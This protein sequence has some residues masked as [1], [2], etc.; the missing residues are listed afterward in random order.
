MAE[1]SWE[2]PREAV[3]VAAPKRLKFAV[4]GVLMLGAV[5]FLMLSGT[6]SG[7]HYF[8]T[9]NDVLSRPDLVGKTVKL[10][11]AVIGNTIKFDADTKTINF[12]I[13]NVPDNAPELQNDGGLAKVLHDSVRNP[14]AKHIDVI[15]QNQAM[16]D[17]LKDE[18]QAILTGKLGSDGVFRAD[19]L[20]LK[21]PSKYAS[22]VPQQVSSN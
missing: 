3:K 6:L 21:C 18:A 4:A 2:K 22:D 8:T 12:T 7:G 14:N 13:A 20:L 5:A 10:S 19:E 17:L 1:V 15:V 11:G 9:V 16:P